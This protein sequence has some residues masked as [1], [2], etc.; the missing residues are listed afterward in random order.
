MLS[1][2]SAGKSYAYILG[3]YL[4]DGCVTKYCVSKPLTFKVNTI[5]TDFADKISKELSSLCNT[6]IHR[7]QQTDKRWSKNSV[8]YQVGCPDQELCLKL[9][10]DTNSKSVI[11]KYVSGWGN[12]LIKEFVV[13]LMDSE[14]YVKGRKTINIENGSTQLTNRMFN[15]GFKSCDTWFFDFMKIVNLLGLKTGK[16]TVDK[17]YKDGYKTPQ[18]F[19]I[20]M[21][22]WVDSGMRFN[23]DRK[24]RRVDEWNSSPAYAHRITY[25]KR[26]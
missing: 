21:Q 25:P 19:S 2:Q 7:S 17:P 6:I 12:E 23:I 16:V 15:M 3:V 5:D 9:R 11:P 8:L 1:S 26:A 18:C 13:G 22:S 4:G 24:N 20:K 10:K 14:G